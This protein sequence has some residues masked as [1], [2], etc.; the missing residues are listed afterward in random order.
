MP[1]MRR[2]LSIILQLG[3]GFLLVFA[4]FNSQGFIEIAVLRSLADQSTGITANSGYYSMSIIY[5]VFTLCNLIAPP[6]IARIGPK[7]SMVF[8]A[9]C[10]TIFLLGFLHLS[11]WLLYSLSALLGLGAALIWTGNGVYLVRF[12]REGKMARNSAIMWTMLQTSLVAGAIFLAFVLHTGDLVSSF[13]FVYTV[14]AAVCAAGILV[15][16]TLPGSP[17]D[18]IYEEDREDLIENEERRE[19]EIPATRQSP[20]AVVLSF[21]EEFVRTFALLKTQNML[22]LIVVFLFSGIE[23]SF[24]TGVFTACLSAF[25]SLSSVHKAIIAYAVLAMGGG[26]IVGGLWFG[27][28]A[29]DTSKFGRS[30]VVLFGM[31]LHIVAYFLCFLNLPMTAPLGN[32]GP[33]EVGYIEPSFIAALITAFMLGLADSAWHTQ[34]YTMLGGIYKDTDSSAAFALFKFFQSL[35]SCAAFY[36][37]SVLLLHWQL[38]F[39]VVMAAAGAV[40]FFTV[41][42]AA[43]KEE[44]FLRNED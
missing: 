25:K 4:A 8:G 14:F 21:G 12:S 40:C 10:Y 36:Y 41:H 2:D 18:I 11:A 30:G 34:L 17:T 6:V 33:G 22:T 32:T 23:T 37:G 24:Y 7:W 39:L 20:P 43:A 5:F 29:K 31:S 13:H 35:A 42:N 16:V 38:L 28:G 26:Q 9:G 15:L 19:V 44:N 1:I 3:F 27:L